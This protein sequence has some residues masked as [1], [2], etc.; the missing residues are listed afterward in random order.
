MKKLCVILFLVLLS[1]SCLFAGGRD[2]ENNQPK[3]L[4]VM[5]KVAVTT[6]DSEV[7]SSGG[8]FEVISNFMDGLM[9]LASDG[10]AQYALCKSEVISADGLTRTYT[11][12]D[13]AFWANG[14]PVTAKDFVFGWRRAIDPETASEYSYF[15]YEIAHVKNAEAINK[16][17]LPL[18]AL[19]V[20]A[21]DDYTLEVTL[22]AP[23][24][25]FDTLLTVPLFFPLNEDFYLSCGDA[26][27]TSPDTLLSNGAFIVTDY[28]PAALMFRMKKNPTYYDADRIHIDGLQFQVLLDSQQ[29]LMS[30]QNGDLDFIYVAGDQIDQVSEDPAFTTVPNGYIWFILPNWG[31]VEK[32]KNQSLRLALSSALNREEI[33]HSVVK[34]GS[35][36]TYSI[37]PQAFVYDEEGHD[38]TPAEKEYPDVC[39]YNPD[40]A[41]KYF[42]QALHSL[43][44]DS[45][46]LELTCDDPVIQQ[47]VAVVIKE[48]LET[49]LPGLHISLRVVPTKQ[50]IMNATRGDFELVLER[51]ILRRSI[52]Q[53][54]NNFKNPC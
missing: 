7:T 10:T 53:V 6:M 49:T 2:E 22:D 14:V 28:Q 51:C 44:V 37:V 11:L 1:C 34:D 17:Q 45:V 39:S 19:G 35:T 54:I 25:F 38:F 30:Y 24:S 32:L 16:G 12:R 15:M 46:D 36:P 27:A 9:Q 5:S 4:K 21:L 20:K 23:V 31:G 33:V 3:I 13:D 29:A 43:G 18:T 8:D 41:R 40:N 42:A 26:F 50:R 47:K 48:Q 52:G